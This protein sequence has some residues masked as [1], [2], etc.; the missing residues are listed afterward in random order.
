[1]SS[2]DDDEPPTPAELLSDADVERISQRVAEV[3]FHRLMRRLAKAAAVSETI[4]APCEKP[5]RRQNRKAQP[6][7]ADFEAVRARRAR[8]GVF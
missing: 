8:K 4:E 6:T 2:P 1:M 5:D 7:A 3:L